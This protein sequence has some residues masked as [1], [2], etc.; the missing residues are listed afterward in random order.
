MRL[1][2]LNVALFALCT[3]FVC[4][5]Y[6]LAAEGQASALE[7]TFAMLGEETTRY[8]LT[9][10]SGSPIHLEVI[11]TAAATMD[12]VLRQ[13]TATWPL[14]GVGPC[15]E[16]R[17]KSTGFGGCAPLQAHACYQY[18]ARGEL[19]LRI[20]AACH[21]VLQVSAVEAKDHVQSCHKDDNGLSWAGAWSCVVVQ[22]RQ[23]EQRHQSFSKREVLRAC[24]QKFGVLDEAYELLARRPQTN[25]NDP[26]YQGR[27]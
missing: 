27:Q 25:K 23:F 19:D 15:D 7:L 26:S 12:F 14:F 3:F 5:L 16:R 10:I 6:K 21:E 22:T 20:M 8:F 2:A 11:I 17:T 18:G 1:T 24:T 13:A 9:R 4:A